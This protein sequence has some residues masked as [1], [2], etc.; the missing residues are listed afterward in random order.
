M[1]LGAVVDRGFIPRHPTRF[2]CLRAFLPSEVI[3]LLCKFVNDELSKKVTRKEATTS[4]HKRTVRPHEI[5]RWIAQRLEISLN[6]KITIDEA[7][8][9]V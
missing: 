6:V 8:K 3:N 1:I 9:S 7:Y 5:W 2:Q 4:T